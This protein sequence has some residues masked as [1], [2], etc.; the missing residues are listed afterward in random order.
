MNSPLNKILLLLITLFLTKR[1][2]YSQSEE[3]I[4]ITASLQNAK[5]KQYILEFKINI[6]NECSNAFKIKKH[7]IVAK[8]DIQEA[9]IGFN[10]R[11]IEKNIDSDWLVNC[12]DMEILPIKPLKNAE[13]DTLTN[14]S[15]KQITANIIRDCEWDKGNYRIQFILYLDYPRTIKYYSNWVYFEIP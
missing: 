9:D 3:K 10:E 2:G 1:N 4:I 15:P 11:R 7:L 14:K 12:F 6:K 13:Y 8:N 5:P